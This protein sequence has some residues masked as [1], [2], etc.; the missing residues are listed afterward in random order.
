MQ[1]GLDVLLVVIRGLQ[2]EKDKININNLLFLI[3]L[4][5]FQHVLSFAKSIMLYM[6]SEME[7]KT[8]NQNLPFYQLLLLATCFGFLKNHNKEI[9]K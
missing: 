6:N 9:I 4:H 3:K 5:C 1:V 7:G 2:H 8:F